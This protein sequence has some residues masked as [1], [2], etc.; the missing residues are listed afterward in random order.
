LNIAVQR[1]AGSRA[2]VVSLSGDIDLAVVPDIREQ[3]EGLIGSGCTE[4]VVDLEGVDYADSTALGLLVWA[5]RKLTPLDGK[6]VLCGANRDVERILALSGLVGV[7]PTITS[8]AD[9]QRALETVAADPDGEEPLWSELLSTPADL[10]HLAG[11]RDRVVELLDRVGMDE[12]SLFD[13]K[14]AVGE[15]LANA[16][17]HGSPKGEQDDVIVQVQAFPDRIG[18]AVSDSGCGFDGAPKA[19]DDVYASSGRG[20]MF[21]RALMDSVQ[22]YRCEGGGTMVT[23]VKSIRSA[24]A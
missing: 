4:V 22:F 21:M 17:R 7:A 15:A 6:L 9:L 2:C 10:E 8:A 19:S 23:L 16:V 1:E 24:T 14:V 12:A 11:M 20:I 18:I 5:D 3:L 13:V